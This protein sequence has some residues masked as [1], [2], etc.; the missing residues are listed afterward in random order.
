MKPYHKKLFKEYY[1]AYAK[2]QRTEDP[3]DVEI[4]FKWAR[5]I[6]RAAKKTISH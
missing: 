5:K 2:S 4:T 3:K 1:L 6:L